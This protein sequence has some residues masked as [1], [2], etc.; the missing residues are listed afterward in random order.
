MVSAAR[1]RI[2][3]NA[4]KAAILKGSEVE[5]WALRI[6]DQ[7]AAGVLTDSQVSEL[8]TM[9]DAYYAEPSE[10]DSE[11]VS[12]EVIDVQEETPATEETE[13]QESSEDYADKFVGLTAIEVWNS[14][15]YRPTK[16]EL[17]QACDWLQVAYDGNETN[18]Q[19]K[20]MLAQSA[21]IEG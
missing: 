3:F 4:I 1:R 21:G 18:E 19:L 5:Y 11:P 7:Q 2:V 14:L 8:E 15:S 17:Q 20:A 9:L 16:R 12:D 6:Y 13:Q 10:G